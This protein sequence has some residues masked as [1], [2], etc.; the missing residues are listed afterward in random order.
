MYSKRLFYR[1]FIRYSS[2]S[3]AITHPRILLSIRRHTR[4]LDI[5]HQECYKDVL[6]NHIMLNLI[7]LLL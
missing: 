7:Q 1:I 5:L 6:F 2:L 3:Y 4:F